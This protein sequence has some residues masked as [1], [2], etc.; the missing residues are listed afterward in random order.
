MKMRGGANNPALFFVSIA[1]IG[2]TWNR[3]GGVGSNAVI[4]MQE[5]VI[6]RLAIIH[7]RYYEITE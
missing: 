1:E 3:G 7:S 4:A 2:H 5:D 6:V